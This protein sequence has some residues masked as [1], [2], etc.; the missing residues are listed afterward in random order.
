MKKTK[1]V[2]SVKYH[3]VA[4]L[5]YNIIM[6]AKIMSQR[7]ADS[8]TLRSMLKSLPQMEESVFNMDKGYA[9]AVRCDGAL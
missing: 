6:A 8:P 3:V 5:N 9:C 1:R 4:I 2:I 7:T